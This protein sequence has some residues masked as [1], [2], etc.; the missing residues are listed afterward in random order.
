MR[1]FATAIDN[2]RQREEYLRSLNPSM[3]AQKQALAAAAQTVNS[4]GQTRLQ[5]SFALQSAVSY[6]L[7]FVVIA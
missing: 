4:I 7:V 3:D 1:N 5:M 2:L 6:P